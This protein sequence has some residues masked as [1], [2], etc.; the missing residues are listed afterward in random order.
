MLSKL[1][2]GVFIGAEMTLALAYFAES[3]SS[4]KTAITGLGEEESRANR[5]KHQLFALHS[6][7][8]NVGYI[9]GPG[10]I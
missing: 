4:Y 5:M 9:F 7:G 8:V 2:S 10:L 6:V 1:L 3:N